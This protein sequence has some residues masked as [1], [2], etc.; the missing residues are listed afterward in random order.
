MWYLPDSF[1]VNPGDDCE[2]VLSP[3]KNICWWCNFF[4][5]TLHYVSNKNLDCWVDF[6]TLRISDNP[7]K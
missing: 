5:D 6:S 3:G 1:Q 4:V 2:Y 7:E